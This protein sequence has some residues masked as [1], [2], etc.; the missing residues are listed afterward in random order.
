VLWRL[1]A[2]AD[3]FR[4]GRG[5]AR[6][7]G[8]VLSAIALVF[9][10]VPSAYAG[11]LTYV[12]HEAATKIFQ[13]AD[14][15]YNPPP[16]EPG[17]TDP[18]FGELPQDSLEPLPTDTPEPLGRFTVL[19]IGVDSGPGRSEALTD[20]MIVASLDPIAGDVS[21]ISVPR[22]MV[23]VPLP[24]GRTFQ[25]KINSLVSYV[26]LYPK[27]FKGA[28]SGEAVLAAALGKLL[29]VH[30]DGWAEV[31]LQGFVKVIN[32]IG[33]VDVTVHEGLCDAT[34]SGFD[35][36]AINPGNYHLDGWN[37]LAYARIRE[38]V[39]QS[40]FTRAARQG[41]VIV[42]ARDRVMKGGFL[43]DPAGFIEGMSDLISTSLD[44]ETISK[45]VQFASIQR[46]HIFRQ[47]ITYPLVH[48]ATNDPRGSVLIPRFGLIHDLAKRAFPPAGTLPKGI[49]TIPE[50]DPGKFKT[51]L[52]SSS[53]CAAPPATATPTPR[54]TPK[55]T[56][57]PTAPPP[58]EESTPEPPAPT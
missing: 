5:A 51:K 3:A 16:I 13:T 48:G 56:P 31:N 37:A 26:H 52:P 30:I 19:L 9:V 32:S 42:A 25:P 45:Y 4:R 8:A 39:G 58:T 28:T 15:P 50:N 24:D 17:D 41:E 21:M 54:P 57:H 27:K 55:P 20:T 10:L 38:S 43:D 22:D 33:G 36:F 12:A 44:A 18:D 29:G 2:V 6:E 34:Y 11:Y 49:E 40:D 14:Q 35:G 23:D 47:V 53:A 7:G 46:D 1:V